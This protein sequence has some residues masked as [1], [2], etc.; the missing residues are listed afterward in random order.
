MATPQT[1]TNEYYNKFIEIMFSEGG[2]SEFE[3]H[4]IKRE[5]PS[6]DENSICITGMAAALSGKKQES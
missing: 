4:K 5:F 6:N 1:K 3:Y 2:I